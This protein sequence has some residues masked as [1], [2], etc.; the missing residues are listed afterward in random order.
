VL[1]AIHKLPIVDAAI[2]TSVHQQP[3]WIKRAKQKKKS[4]Q[5]RSQNRIVD[6]KRHHPNWS[7]KEAVAV[8]RNQ[9]SWLLNTIQLP[10][11]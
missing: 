2:S 9:F 6:P 4:N 11:Q 5:T 3:M 7:S 1:I 8:A 10:E